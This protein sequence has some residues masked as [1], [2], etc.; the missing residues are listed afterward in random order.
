VAPVHGQPGD[1]QFATLRM[2]ELLLGAAKIKV[3]DRGALP[4]HCP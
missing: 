1:H 2:L 4:L 3:D